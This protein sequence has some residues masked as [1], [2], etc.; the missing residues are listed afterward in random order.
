VSWRSDLLL[1]VEKR[2]LAHL[3]ETLPVVG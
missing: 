3:E 2:L 1:E